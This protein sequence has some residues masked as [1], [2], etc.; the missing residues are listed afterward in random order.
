MRSIWYTKESYECWTGTIV[1]NRDVVIFFSTISKNRD[2]ESRLILDPRSRSE[3]LDLGF[4]VLDSRSRSNTINRVLPGIPFQPPA[5]IMFALLGGELLLAG[6][7]ADRRCAR[8][9]LTYQSL[10]FVRFLS[11]CSTLYVADLHFHLSM[12][13]S[14]DAHQCASASDSTTARLVGFGTDRVCL[15]SRDMPL[16]F[17]RSNVDSGW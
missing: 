14:N 4:R 6:A 2:R 16:V 8:A 9:L 11:C 17:G 5:F 12:S 15:G 10:S 1:E 13:S 7:A 3:I